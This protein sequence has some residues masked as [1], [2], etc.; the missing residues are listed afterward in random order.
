MKN[1]NCLP[2]TFDDSYALI[3]LILVV[4]YIVWNFLR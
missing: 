1:R 4:G 3:S 2:G